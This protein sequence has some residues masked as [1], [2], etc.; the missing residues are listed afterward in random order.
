MKPGNIPQG[1]KSKPRSVVSL[2]NDDSKLKGASVS[3]S[4]RVG[5][6]K[7]DGQMDKPFKG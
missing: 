7:K 6:T 3:G 2:V 4:M 5:N 1:N